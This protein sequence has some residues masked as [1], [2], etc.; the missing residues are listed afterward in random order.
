MAVREFDGVDDQVVL[1]PGAL[2]S[3]NTDYTILLLIKPIAINFKYPISFI[4]TAGPDILAALGLNAVDQWQAASSFGTS[5]STLTLNNTTWQLLA[6]SKAGGNATPRFHRAVLGGAYTHA[7]GASVMGQP[8]T[9][10]DRVEIGSSNSA[11]FQNMRLAVAAV[12]TRQLSDAEFESIIDGTDDIR[13]VSGGGPS[14]LWQF[15]QT[16]T[17]DPIIDRTGGGADQV[18]LVGTSVI[19]TDNPAWTFETVLPSTSIPITDLSITGVAPPTAVNAD[20][21][22]NVLDFNDGRVILE[23]I[24]TSG[25]SQTVTVETHITVQGYP[26]N[27]AVITVPAGATRFVGPFPPTIFNQPDGT[28]IVRSSVGGTTLKFRAYRIPRT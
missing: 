21:V 12:W 1:S 17:T 22:K 27:D 2:G 19:T 8:S 14:T 20:A 28:V 11:N 15:N 26:V 5:I 25:T 4:R 24:S 7:D 23:I 16:V 13:N 3:F 18:S 10:C 9:L 6:I